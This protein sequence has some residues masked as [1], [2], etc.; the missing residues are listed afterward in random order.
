MECSC[1]D[2][3][4]PATR[5]VSAMSVTLSIG[6]TGGLASGK[7]TVARLFEKLGVPVIDADKVARDIVAPGSPALGAVVE[8]FGADILDPEG[9]LDRGRMREVVFAHDNKRQ[10]LEAILHPRIRQEMNNRLLELDAP[11]AISMIPL[12]IETRQEKR[13]DRILVVD[14][15]P[16]IQLARAQARDGSTQE[17]LRGILDAQ[18]DR[19][20]RLAQADDVIHNN[21]G[22]EELRPQVEQ[23]HE[24]YLALATRLRA[25]RHQ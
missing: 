14:T 10:E 18:I 25:D 24:R 12:L 11:Y 23:L 22:L 3:E 1:I 17:I 20:T 4:S 5:A 19:D 9:A 2:E 8:R 13:F 21:H 7:S 6:L 16:C 15:T